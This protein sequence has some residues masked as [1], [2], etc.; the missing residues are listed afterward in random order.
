MRQSHTARLVALALLSTTALSAAG[1]TAGA[2]SLQSSRVHLD[3]SLPVHPALQYGAQVEPDKK[4][5]VIV[6]KTSPDVDVRDVAQGSGATVEEE[7]PFISSAVLEVAQRA[8]FGLG[9]DPHVRYVSPDSGVQHHSIDT[10]HLTTTYEAGVQ[11]TN[12]WNSTSSSTQA[13]GNGITVAVVDTGLDTSHPDFPAG[14]ELAVNLT[15]TSTTTADGHGHGTHVA[16]IIA[17]RNPSGQYLGV[18]PDARVIGVKISDD[19]GNAHESDMLRGLQWVYDNRAT[20]NIRAVN[21]SSAVGTAESYKT[22]AVDA[23]VE[24]LW[25]NG[26]TVVVAA[27]NRGTAADAVS[28]AP[29]NDPYV[30]TVGC[31]DDNVT[32]TTYTDD[33]L[34]TFSSR[35]TTQDGY[36]K[37]DLVAPGRK[38]VSS[39]ASTSAVLAQQ[40]PSHMSAD[41]V[42]MRLSGT[43]MAAP[44]VTGTVA[45]LL[46]RVPSLTPNQI[47]WLLQS[48]SRLYPGQ[49]SRDPAGEVNAWPAM[50]T[51]VNPGPKGILSANSGLVPN[52]GINPTTKTVQWGTYYWDTYHW[53]TYY[54]DTYHWDVTSY[55]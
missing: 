13:T 32:A 45:L 20:Y 55:D 27:G 40:L 39:L 11:A 42:H 14:K 21:I 49:S 5:R 36:A 10:S 8:V 2:A 4:V 52:N 30:I 51:A 53:D 35:G 29:A 24:Q 3:P 28:Y 34:C 41:G 46:Q 33:S 7:F 37:P 54:W 12:I 23:A 48:N 1:P 50:S 25:L 15:N 16:G 31:L 38:I 18:A 9:H 19:S 6:R 44:V 43:S 26:I 47:K 17:A 22:S